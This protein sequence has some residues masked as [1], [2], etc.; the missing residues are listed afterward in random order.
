MGQY[1]TGRYGTPV[2]ATVAGT[3]ETASV[4]ASLGDV[5][6]V[7]EHG[8]FGQLAKAPTGLAPAMWNDF[9]DPNVGSSFV[10][11]AHAG[12]QYRSLAQLSLHY[13]SAWSQDDRATPN[14]QPDGSID[15]VGA[16]VRVTGG[17]FGH[18]YAGAA[19]VKANHARTVSGVIRV[20]NARGGRA[21]CPNTWVEQRRDWQAR[22]WPCNAIYRS[23]RC[24]A[25]RSPSPATGGPRGERVRIH[26]VAS[27]DPLFDGV[28]R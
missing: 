13:F 18:L 23:A 14:Q 20:L 11:H 9:A 26:R 25:T 27:D 21:S 22:R 16:D 3:G 10:Q 12:L 1:D 2:M 24:S 8:I 28:S 5:E 17:R 4:A 7:A 6:L 19:Q 15:V